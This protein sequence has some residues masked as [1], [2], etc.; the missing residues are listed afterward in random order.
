VTLIRNETAVN[1]GLKLAII[2][3]LNKTPNARTEESRMQHGQYD[4]LRMIFTSFDSRQTGNCDAGIIERKPSALDGLSDVT[5][6][7]IN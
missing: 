7:H 4:P 2:I 5:S 3:R 1:S 6:V